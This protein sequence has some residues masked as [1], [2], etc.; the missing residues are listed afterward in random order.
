MHI[1]L[2]MAERERAA[3]PNKRPAIA[4]T[5]SQLFEIGK[6]LQSDEE[7]VGYLTPHGSF[8]ETVTK[9]FEENSDIPPKLPLFAALATLSAMLLSFRVQLRMGGSYVNPDLWITMLAPSGS[10][11]SLTEKYLRQVAPVRGFPCGSTGAQFVADLHDY[12]RS[13]WFQDE[14]GAFLDLL[15]RSDAHADIKRYLL[16]AYDGSPIS[17]RTKKESIEIE[18]PALTILGTTVSHLF[19]QQMTAESMLS[20]FAQRFQYVYVDGSKEDPQALYTLEEEK[21]IA[22][23][24]AKWD[25]ILNVPR[26]SMYTVSPHAVEAYTDGFRDLFG[27]DRDVDR[28]FFRRILWRAPRYALIYHFL[29]GKESSVIDAEDM[30]WGL[31]PCRVHLQDFRRVMDRFEMSTLAGILEKAERVQKR[32]QAKQGRAATARDIIAGVGGIKDATTAKFIID[33]LSGRI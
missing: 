14:F 13:F 12:N 27:I 21:N 30:A 16:L 9:V 15:E 1:L 29:L 17:R 24:K 22:A 33:V 2:E 25:E 32:I 20:G 6:K 28:S 7:Q 5:I 31:R 26:H 3:A 10:G 8:L 19:S 18:E 11:K 4:G 23:G